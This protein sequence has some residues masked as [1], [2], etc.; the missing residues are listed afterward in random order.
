MAS[1][2]TSSSE[3]S[4]SRSRASRISPESALPSTPRPKVAQSRTSLSESCVSRKRVLAPRGSLGKDPKANATLNRTSGLGCAQKL[5]ISGTARGLSR[6]PSA[7][8]PALRGWNSVSP[9]RDLQSRNRTLQ[10]SCWSNA[11]LF[12]RAGRA[13]LRHAPW[14]TDRSI[15]TNRLLV[16]RSAWSRYALK[17]RPL[18]TPRHSHN[19]QITLGRRVRR[20]PV[21][22]YQEY[23]EPSFVVW[24][25]EAFCE[26]NTSVKTRSDWDHSAK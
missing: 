22:S 26:Q 7:A 19:R 4:R 15:C 24:Y 6:W 14:I 17:R 2:R 23:F 5:A 18:S 3:S 8:M 16:Q 11:G 25:Q 9:E 21:T 12:C 10:G 1:S 20:C 13:H